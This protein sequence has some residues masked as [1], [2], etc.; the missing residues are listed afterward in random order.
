ML[1]EFDSVADSQ[2]RTTSTRQNE[3]T[4]KLERITEVNML[5]AALT[6]PEQV[7]VYIQTE[8]LDTA[9]TETGMIEK[10]GD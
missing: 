6:G 5:P 3:A 7:K 10:R 2:L 8:G 4:L 1:Y 9:R